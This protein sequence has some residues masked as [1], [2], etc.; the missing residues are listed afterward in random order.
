MGFWAQF[1]KRNTRLILTLV[2]KQWLVF[3]IGTALLWFKC[4]TAEVWVVLASVVIGANVFQK[5]QGVQPDQPVVKV[6][7]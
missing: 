5:W 7:E 4:I 3:F 1:H 6:P 2:S